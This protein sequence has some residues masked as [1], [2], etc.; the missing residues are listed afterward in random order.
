MQRGDM[1]LDF[2]RFL[3]GE[4]KWWKPCISITSTEPLLYRPLFEAI[5]VI[6][7]A[8]LRVELTTNGI[9]LPEFADALLDA[10]VDSVCVSLDGPEEVHDRVRGYRGCFS[11]A[12]E[13]IRRIAKGGRRSMDFR[14]STTIL[15]LNQDKLYD[16]VKA[17]ERF[18]PKAHVFTH[19][20]FVTE[21]M[22][23]AHNQRFPQ[24]KATSSSVAVLD[25]RQINPTTVL[26]QVNLM[27]RDFPHVKVVPNLNSERLIKTYYHEHSRFLPGADHCRAVFKVAQVSA[28]GYLFG[29][30]RC[31]NYPLGH[32]QE[33]G[34]FMN[35]WN[36][37]VMK[38]F[39]EDLINAGGAFP[40]CTAAADSSRH[41][42]KSMGLYR[43]ISG[44]VVKRIRIKEHF[45]LN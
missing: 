14:I 22:A 21:E 12:V 30:T 11:R 44:K 1:S 6:K 45:Y 10:R 18:R 23:E 33:L 19:M 25:P 7:D 37:S 39:R 38:R 2:I 13:G 42:W 8:G 27:R 28:D 36:G 43:L 4:V 29:S 32:V 15:P 17:V 40:A 34:G 31:L 41:I 3:V 20:N 16:A 24:Y 9:L 35:A 26:A 5:K